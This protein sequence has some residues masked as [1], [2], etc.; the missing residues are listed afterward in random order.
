MPKV[1]VVKN[2]SREGSGLIG[3][4]LKEKNIPVDEVDLCKTE[5]P[6]PKEYSAVF[7]MGGPDSAN[8]DTYKMK[9]EIKRIKETIDGEIPYFGICL[10]MQALVKAVGGSVYKSPV[11]EVGCKDITENNYEI[12]LTEEG[13]KD[14]LFFGVGPKFPVFQLHEDTVNLTQG[15]ALLG[16]GTSNCINQVVKV[17]KNAYGVQGHLELNAPLFEE[18][19]AEDRNLGEVDFSRKNYN[20]LKKEYNFNGRKVIENFLQIAGLNK[21]D[22]RTSNSSIDSKISRM[23]GVSQ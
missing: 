11:K 2:I 6:S 10:G 12:I 19:L 21:N 1:L 9:N 23:E 22:D 20:G 18:W 7:V 3:E 8:D 15:I 17:G 14:P 5:F 4:M 13:M 16:T